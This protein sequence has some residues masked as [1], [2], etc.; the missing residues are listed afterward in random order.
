M[1]LEGAE[2]GR[3]RRDPVGLLVRHGTWRRPP[4]ALGQ[5]QSRAAQDRSVILLRLL[6]HLPLLSFFVV[7]LEGLD[8]PRLLAQ[9]VDHEGHRKVVETVAPRHL[10]DDVGANEVVASVQHTNVALATTNI[11]ELGEGQQTRD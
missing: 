4:R 7:L 10:Q 6:R 3:L 8:R 9:E 1:H 5:H 11:H 2:S